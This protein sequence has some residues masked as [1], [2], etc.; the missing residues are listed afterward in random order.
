[1]ANI[2]IL[3]KYF[4]D[5]IGLHMSMYRTD[6]TVIPSYRDIENQYVEIDKTDVWYQEQLIDMINRFMYVKKS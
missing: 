6:W 4:I 2:V 3:P 5:K 1:M